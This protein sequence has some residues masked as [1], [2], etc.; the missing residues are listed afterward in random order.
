MKPSIQLNVGQQLTLTPQLQQAIK[1]LQLSTIELQHEIAE[2]IESNP[3][4]ELVEDDNKS[5]DGQ[6]TPTVAVMHDDS[7][8][9]L[10]LDNDKLPKELP[11]DTAWEDAMQTH[12]SFKGHNHSDANYERQQTETTSIQDHLLWQLNMSSLSDIDHAI[13][14]AIIDAIND[15]GFLTE[16]CENIVHCLNQASTSET[17]N[18]A[19]DIDEVYAVLSHIQNFDPT[20]VGARDLREC[21][22]L[23][24]K[25]L[26]AGTPYLSTASN[27]V[28]HHFNLLAKRDYK[29]LCRKLKITENE[30]KKTLSLIQSLNPKPGLNIVNETSDYVIPDVIITKEKGE[31]TVRLNGESLPKVNIN[32]LYSSYAKQVQTQQDQTYMRDQMQEAKWFLKSLQSRNETLLKVAQSIFAKQA[33]FLEQGEEAMKPL[34]LQDIAKEIDMHESTISRVTT[35]KFAITPRGLFELKYFFSSHVSTQGGGECSSTAIRA[36]IKKLITEESPQKPL[37]DAKIA[38]FLCD[39]GINVARRTIAKYRESMNIPPSNERRSI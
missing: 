39:K 37:S 35:Q 24:L 20:G 10:A 34:V 8:Q 9:G 7:Q 14:V 1:L 23:Q 38:A 25:N 18:E 11:I 16:S 36:L 26:A 29:Q 28:Q 13:A 32:T 6:D 22:H 21:I 27:L 4:L 17:E 30:L 2:I 5:L 19:V 33:D 12:A 15:E 3:M 31:W